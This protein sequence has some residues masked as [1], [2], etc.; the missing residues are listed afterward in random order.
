[1]TPTP[2]LDAESQAYVTLLR[3]YYTPLVT[4]DQAEKLCYIQVETTRKLS[5]L[6]PC[7]SPFADMVAVEQTLRTQL[8]TAVPPARWQAQHTAL[9]QAVQGLLGVQ[10]DELAAIDAQ[11]IARFLSYNERQI[12]AF[13]AFC[14]I[15]TQL[16][17]G[18]PPLSPAFSP[19]EPLFCE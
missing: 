19:V 2:T 5:D 14:P 10:S 1:V 8:A 9:Q 7:R 11:D 13:S 15:V 4:A 3:T 12:D 17:T 18:P 16:N 6:L